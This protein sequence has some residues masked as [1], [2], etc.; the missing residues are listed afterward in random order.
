MAPHDVPPPLGDDRPLEGL[1]VIELASVLAGPLVGT[2]LAELGAEVVKAEM[3]GIGDVTRSWRLSGESTDGPSAYYVA[4]NGPKQGLRLN[5]KTET[6]QRELDAL[7]AEADILLQNARP[8]SLE[9]LGLD[10]SRLAERHPRL[11]HV[12]LLGFLD[13][14]GRAGY[15][16]VVQAE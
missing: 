7:L 14:P 3:P 11:I 5:L 1:K 16:I 12:H 8:D 4:A 9:A 15:D 13:Q 2:F 6:G 10:P